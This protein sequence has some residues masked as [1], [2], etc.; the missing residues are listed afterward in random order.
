MLFFISSCDRPRVEVEF[1]C[2]EVITKIVELDQRQ[3]SYENDQFSNVTNSS[4]ELA[5]I[6]IEITSM[7][8]V[9]DCFAFTALPQVIESLTIR[10][11]LNV[12]SA[13]TLYTS[14][15]N[16]SE[17]F[18][19]H[20]EDQSYSIEN[21]INAHADDPLIFHSDDQRMVLQLIDK[22]DEVIDQ[23]F[24]VSFNFDDG[25]VKILTISNLIISN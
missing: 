17:L 15:T 20:L 10:S 6:L 23:S 8:G 16:L 1:D 18:E 14:G 24:D 9:P 21:F 3:G 13:G 7:S 11:D 5:A 25:E 19:V 2:G 12:V 4:F 22:P